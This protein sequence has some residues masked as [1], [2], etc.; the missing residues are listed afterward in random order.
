MKKKI[1]HIV[2]E[3]HNE[4]EMYN[5]FEEIQNKYNLFDNCV[6]EDCKPNETI[7]DHDR[8]EECGILWVDEELVKKYGE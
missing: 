8:F 6:I 2:I 7:I 4:V 3:G 5:L 1:W